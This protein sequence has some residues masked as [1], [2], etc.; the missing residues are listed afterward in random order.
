M[1]QGIKDAVSPST[2][3]IYAKGCGFNNDDASGL[4]EAVKAASKADVA[5]VVLGDYTGHPSIEGE[6][7][8]TSGE[9]N[10]LASLKF[11]GMQQ[12]LLDAVSAT[13]TPVVLVAQIGRP[14]DLSAASRQTEAIIV[15]W[16]PGQE[17]GLATADV[18]FGDYNPAGRLPMTFP[19]SA[20][21]LPLTYN[22]KT[23]GRR[24]EY[25]DMDF[26]PLYRFGYGMSYTSFAYSNLRIATLPDGNV[27]VKADV[28]NTGQRAGDEVAQLYVTDMYA[29][30]K[31][32]VM[33]LK[34]FE[35]ISLEPGQTK[36][37]TFMLTPYDL[38][39]LN[40]DMDRVVESGDFKIMVGGMSP[41]YVAKDNIKDS[42]SYPDGHGVM[43]TLRYD[44]PASA[45]F[46]FAVKDVRRMLSDGS[47][48]VTVEVVNAGNLTDTGTLCMYVDGVRTGDTRHYELDPGESKLITFRVPGAGND[49]KSLNFVSRHSNLTYNK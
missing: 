6:K 32:R 26:Y 13:G 8:A 4:S 24:Y 18:L 34:G 28:T 19:Q 37:V 29:S 44:L 43:G 1:L 20:A 45:K 39:L 49:W 42:L 38:S 15:N 9:N 22:F 27:E 11:Q 36:T 40:V 7:R 5:V 3:V 12:A 48:D 33:E 2:K 41:D 17:G 47:D 30:V 10:D 46:E 14:Y 23:S 16:F 35:R 31:T 21:Q 25:V